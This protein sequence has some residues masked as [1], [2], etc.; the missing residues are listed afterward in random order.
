MEE[1]EAAYELRLRMQRPDRMRV[2][3]R[4]LGLSVYSEGLGSRGPWQQRLLQRSPRPTSA[5]GGEAI[6]NGAEGSA[7]GRSLREMRARGH[8]LTLLPAAGRDEIGVRVVFRNGTRRDYFVDPRTFR[9]VRSLQTYA[10]HPDMEGEAARTRTIETT[11]ADYRR[12]AGYLFPMRLE[13][14]DRD[15]GK[16]VQTVIVREVRIN[17][18][19]E[20]AIFESR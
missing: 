19:L 5:A 6:V 12:V 15:S 3:L 2:D 7:W 4:K 20:A 13:N 17:E 18:P 8:S 11:Y 1:A 9:I 10:L 16:V 14:R